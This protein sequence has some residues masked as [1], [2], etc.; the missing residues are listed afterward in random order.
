MIVVADTSAL[1]AAFDAA[2]SEHSASASVMEDEVLLV[3]PL[4]LTELDHLIRRDFGFPAALR[5]AQALTDRITDGH[6]RL[7]S[8]TNDDLTSAAAVRERYAGLELDLA[9]AVGVILADRYRTNLIFT[10]DHR[11]YRA[12]APLTTTFDAFRL[13]PADR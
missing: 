8:L 9:D 1:F 10:L 3:S 7:A 4:V 2:Q 13:L 6:Y 12:I 11:D 5:V